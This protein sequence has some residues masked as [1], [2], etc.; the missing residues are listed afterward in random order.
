MGPWASCVAHLEC[1]LGCVGL[2]R[3]RLLGR[4]RLVRRVREPPAAH[5]ERARARP[6][7]ALLRELLEERVEGLLEVHAEGLVR[8]NHEVDGRHH[9]RLRRV[10]CRRG[11]Q[12]E[13]Q[14]LAAAGGGV[15]DH[16]GAGGHRREGARLHPAQRVRREPLPLGR[17]RGE[18]FVD[19]GLP[20]C[21]AAAGTWHATP[22]RWRAILVRGVEG[23]RGPRGVPRRGQVGR[24]WVRIRDCSHAPAASAV[25]STRARLR[26]VGV[27]GGH[28]FGVR[29]GGDILTSSVLKFSAAGRASMPEECLRARAALWQG[30]SACPAVL[31]AA[32]DALELCPT[33]STVGFAVPP[34]PRPRRHQLSS[35]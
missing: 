33:K 34:R 14:P 5:E 18:V 2:R 4:L 32:R 31:T 8:H 21:A 22:T 11:R 20:T 15:D 26:G 10:P 17:H 27:R 6:Q 12:H 25:C 30:C 28:M 3:L 9:A 13:Q 35:Y 19:S 23:V 16:V 1:A 24:N 29:G 7:P